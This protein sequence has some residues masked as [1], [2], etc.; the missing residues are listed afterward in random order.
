MAEQRIVMANEF[1]MGKGGDSTAPVGYQPTPEEKEAIKLVDKLYSKAK[2]HRA[3][4]DEKWLDFYKMFR[5][6]QWKETR[7]AYRHSEVV[8]LIF[9]AIQSTVPILTDAK[10]RIE[11]LPQEPSDREFA[12]LMSK[13]VDFEWTKGNWQEELIEAIYDA[14]F[15]GAGFLELHID[16]DARDG[17]GAACLKSSD[18]FYHFPDPKARDVNKECDFYI[19]AEPVDVELLKAEYPDK[20]QFIKPDLLDMAQ[21]DNKTDFDQVKFKSPVDNRSLVEGTSS[22]DVKERNKALKQTLI[23][24]SREFEEEEKIIE[25]DKG[26]TEVKYVQKLKYPNGRKIVKVGGVLLEDEPYEPEHGKFPYAR[27]LNYTLPREFWGISEVEQL[28]GPQKTF[29]KLIS[30]ALDVLTLMGNPIWVVDTNS[31]IDTENLFNR[32]G[33]IVEKEPGSE[34]RR[35][36]GVQLQPYVLQMVELMKSWFDDIQGQPEVSR[37]IKPEAVSAASAIE[38]LQDAANQRLRLKSRHIDAALQDLGQMYASLVMQYYTAPQVFRLTN[39]QNVDQYF[40]FHV[41]HEQDESGNPLMDERGSPIRMA[42]VREIGIDENGN[43]VVGEEK[44][45][46]IRG[47]LDVKVITGSTLPFIKA[48]REGLAFRLLQAGAIDQPELLQAVEW[49][50]WEATWERV[51]NNQAAMA[52]AAQ[53]PQG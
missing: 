19:Y 28:E 6:R 27:I 46:Q 39:N 8:N 30:F 33:L 22:Y 51:K 4:Y 9:R 13:L 10:P 48:Q 53:P 34:V 15:Y 31:G 26:E 37:G 24:K 44:S 17:I 12:D 50:N 11:F 25:N 14:H 49:P 21:S 18:P 23:L 7:P 52:A 42:K 20:A 45:F 3:Q 32:P 16:D 35:E 29:N 40:K 1:T 47:K 41:E 38:A 2:K 5:G 43:Q 36:T